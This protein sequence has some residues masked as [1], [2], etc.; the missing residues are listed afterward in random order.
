MLS[1]IRAMLPESSIVVAMH[2]SWLV[3]MAEQH[4]RLPTGKI[5]AFT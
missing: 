4:I 3:A 5:P 1:T 2:D